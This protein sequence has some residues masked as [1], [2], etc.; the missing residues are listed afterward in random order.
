MTFKGVFDELI[1]I[2][3]GTFMGGGEFLE[4]AFEF[5]F[6]DGS[7]SYFLGGYGFSIGDIFS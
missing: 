7:S 4:Y 1:I 6:D 2:V 3:A 5:A